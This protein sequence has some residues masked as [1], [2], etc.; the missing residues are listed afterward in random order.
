[1]NTEKE[2][3]IV[4]KV[5]FDYYRHLV[6]YHRAP[7][8]SASDVDYDAM[9]AFIDRAAELVDISAAARLNSEIEPE[10][11]GLELLPND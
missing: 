11:D 6:N 10:H 1:M 4:K 9:N 8:K 7:H 5:L 3:E 2:K